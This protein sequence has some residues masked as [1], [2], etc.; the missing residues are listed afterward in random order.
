[1]CAALAGLYGTATLAAGA[2]T[3][4]D[5]VAKASAAGMAEVQSGQVAVQ[6]AGSAQ[7]RTYGQMMVDDHGKANKE[8]ETLAKG[9]GLQL[10]PGPTDAQKASL[11][12]L[13]GRSGADF[14]AS[15]AHQMV[16]DHEDAVS[17]FTQASKL[18]DAALAGFAS[19]TLP[20]LQHHLEEARKLEKAR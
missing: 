5:F 2:L 16:L 3:P 17:L 7:V 20:T 8:L 10:A 19:K 9:K 13:K 11:E 12:K 15:Y 18:T 1:M 14:D 4:Q 6:K